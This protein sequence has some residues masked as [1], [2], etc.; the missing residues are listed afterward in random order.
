M[1]IKAFLS[2]SGSGLAK[3]GSDPGIA[4]PD[5]IQALVNLDRIQTVSTPGLCIRINIKVLRTKI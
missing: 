1:Q 3:S 5:R 2:E 4:N